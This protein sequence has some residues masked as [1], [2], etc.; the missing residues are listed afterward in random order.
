VVLK[1]ASAPNPRQAAAAAEAL[2]ARRA[3]VRGAWRA[4]EA[5]AAE[6][7]AVGRNLF[8]CFLC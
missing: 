5:Q 7:D 8:C 4:L 6:D 1:P 2:N 3:E